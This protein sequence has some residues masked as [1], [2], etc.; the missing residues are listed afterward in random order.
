MDDATPQPWGRM[1]GLL[2]ASG[3]ILAGV[4][5]DLNPDVILIRALVAGAIIGAVAGILSRV[6]TSIARD[7]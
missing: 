2:A 7:E 5:R 3:A 6:L 4:V 1:L